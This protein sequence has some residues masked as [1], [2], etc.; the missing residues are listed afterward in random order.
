MP[1]SVLPDLSPL[2]GGLS[3]QTGRCAVPPALS[4]AHVGQTS[5]A[6]IRCRPLCPTFRAAA[7]YISTAL[8]LPVSRRTS[9]IVAT[10]LPSAPPYDSPPAPDPLRRKQTSRPLLWG[11]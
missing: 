11:A 6:R 8:G 7:L 1:P 9:Y 10:R 5:D 4:T 2:P 3:G